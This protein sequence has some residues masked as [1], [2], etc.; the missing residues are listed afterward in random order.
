MIHAEILG[1][2][3]RFFPGRNTVR[4][5]FLESPRALRKLLSPFAYTD[6]VA[7]PIPERAN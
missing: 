2:R 4:G 1:K 7:A 5:H 3:C 6:F